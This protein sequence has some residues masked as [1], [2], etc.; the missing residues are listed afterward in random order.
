MPPIGSA[1]PG[2]QS[3]ALEWLEPDLLL[4]RLGLPCLILQP[5]A[6]SIGG[7]M[8]GYYYKRD[9]TVKADL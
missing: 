7:N 5:Q 1:T 8:D 6:C 2:F 3:A 9:T 4:M